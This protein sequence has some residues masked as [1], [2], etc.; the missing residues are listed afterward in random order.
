MKNTIIFDLDGVITSEEAYWDAAGLVLHE[1]LYSPRYWNVKKEAASQHYMPAQDASTSH[2]IAHETLPQQVIVGLKARAI[3]SNWD[4]CYAGF[5]WYLIELLARIPDITSLL[6]LRPADTQWIAVFREK[7]SSVEA[8]HVSEQGLYQLFDLPIFAD[9]MGMEFLQRFDT[10]ASERLGQPIEGVFARYSPS[11]LFCQDLFQ[12]WYLGDTLY[13][14]TYGHAPQQTGKPG[15]IYFERPLFPLEQLQAMLESL[16][17]QGYMFGIAT[18]RPRQEALIPLEQYGLLPYFSEAHMVTDTDV[19]RVEEALRATGDKTMLVKP[20]PFPFL[21]AANPA[22]QVGDP[23]PAW[24]SFVVVGDTTSDSVGGRA[25]G[26]LT[27]A[28]LTGARTPEARRALEASQP[29]FIIDDVRKLPELMVQIDGLDTIQRLQFTDARKAA[30]LLQ[31][32][33]ARHMHLYVDSVTLTPKAVSLNSFNGFYRLHDEEYFFKTHVEDKGVLEEYY[34]AELLHQAGYHIVRPLRTLHE[35]GRQMVIYPVVRWPVMF[36]LVR[37]VE[38]HEPGNENSIDMEALIAAERLECEHLLAIYRATLSHTSA[39]EHARA[40]IHQLFWHRLAG[41]RFKHFYQG[42]QVMLPGDTG[43]TLAFEQVMHS[44]WNVNGVVLEN[45]LEQLIE[46]ANVVLQPAQEAFTVI[47]HGDAHFGNV[48][49]EEQRRYL[50]FDPA[51]AGRHS[52]LL[53]VVKPLFHNVFATWMYF[54]QEVAQEFELTVAV[55][56]DTLFIEHTHEVSPIREAILQTK[57]E[58]LLTPLVEHLR[59]VNALPQNWYEIM[60]SALLCCPL[61]TINLLDTVRFP[62]KV[63][64]LGLLLTMLMGHIEL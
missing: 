42:K 35:Q 43:E 8:V 44:R 39:E 62:D 54:P 9:A 32:W 52:P 45:T 3:N 33:F 2:V 29:D 26:A 34:H 37:A 47:G 20:H 60:Q 22:Y 27:V 17:S 10:Y 49:L 24:G 50:Y 40:P 64:W 31:R 14:Q 25:A 56:G 55:R 4:T 15:C 63:T 16:R 1:L 58:Y 13:A 30:M 61:L 6:P 38:T 11:W 48:F 12:E 57:M 18:G 5:C 59:V 46:R 23:V 41:E 51:F 36:D 19:I 7:L 53:D 28:V 21:R